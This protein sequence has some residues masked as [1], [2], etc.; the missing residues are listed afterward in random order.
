LEAVYVVKVCFIDQKYLYVPA[1]LLT[2]NLYHVP[3]GRFINLVSV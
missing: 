1:P 3:L 2:K